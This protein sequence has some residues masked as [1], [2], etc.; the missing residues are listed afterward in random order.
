VPVL[1]QGR[2]SRVLLNSPE[3]GTPPV[4]IPRPVAT[5]LETSA[6]SLRQRR[7]RERSQMIPMSAGQGKRS[8]ALLLERFTV[9]PKRRGRL[10]LFLMGEKRA[11]DL[12]F[13]KK[14]R[15]D[16]TRRGASGEHSGHQ[17][18]RI[19]NYGCKCRTVSTGAY[20]YRADW[21]A[22]R[23]SAVRIDLLG[24]PRISGARTGGSKGES[25]EP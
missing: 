13:L 10:S 24:A 15:H 11:C 8:S 14:T 4:S 25:W 22:D 7:R 18:A 23:K 19:G 3:S 5:E 6:S 16:V 1:R 20:T 21:L 2:F 17:R 9:L 12:E